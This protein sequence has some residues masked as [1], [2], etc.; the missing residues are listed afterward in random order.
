[1]KSKGFT[2][3]AR[4]DFSADAAKV[5]LRMR[6]TQL[7]IFSN[8]K[9]GTPL[10]MASPSIAIDLPLKALAGEDAQRQVWLSYNA[11][12]HLNRQH[13]LRD[14]HLKNGCF[15]EEHLSWDNAEYMK[16]LGIGR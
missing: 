10:M 7:L 3:F 15:S 11:P 2:V 13:S 16:Q 8:P 4:I 14:E 9:G 6:S 5:G 1:V 12:E